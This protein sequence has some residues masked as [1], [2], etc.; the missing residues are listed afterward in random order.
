MR[1]G[2]RRKSIDPSR[3]ARAWCSGRWGPKRARVTQC[4][5]VLRAEDVYTQLL[6][7]STDR[8]RPGCSSDLSWTAVGRRFDI[9]FEL[10]ANAVWRF[11][12]VFLRCPRCCRLATRIYVPTADSWPG[13]RRCWG[14]TYESRQRRNYKDTGRFS[15]LG[16]T[17]RDEAETETWDE[18]QRRADAAA[19]R[20]AERRTIL[21]RGAGT[22]PT[23][24]GEC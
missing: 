3:D 24:L 18:R 7:G 23:R 20:Y 15:A 19:A 5:A 2:R 14:L 4:A 22:D 17:L 8:L 10:R 16:L 12:R 21:S 6:R 13:C 11:C 1:G 9:V